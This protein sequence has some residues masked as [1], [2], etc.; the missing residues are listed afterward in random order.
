LYNFIHPIEIVRT[1]PTEN[2]PELEQK[3][4]SSNTKL[5]QEMEVTVTKTNHE[6]MSENAD[7]K[8]FALT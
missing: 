6:V 2:V 3:K 4:V 7:T 1:V 5:P 8:S